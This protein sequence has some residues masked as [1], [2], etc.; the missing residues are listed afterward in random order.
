MFDKPSLLTKRKTT[1]GGGAGIPV[2]GSDQSW[3][4]TG[5]TMPVGSRLVGI[6]ESIDLFLF[7]RGQFLPLDP[8]R[9]FLES[10]L[11]VGDP[12]LCQGVGIPELFGETIAFH[13]QFAPSVK[14][15]H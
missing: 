9:P 14:M 7:D 3:G 12:S 2:D 11:K 4:K 15:L 6:N 5:L 8:Q 10:K 1:H 13:V